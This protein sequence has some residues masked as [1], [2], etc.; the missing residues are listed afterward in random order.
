[1]VWPSAFADTV[2][3]PKTSPAADLTVPLSTTSA[4]RAANADVIAMRTVQPANAHSFLMALLLV[5]ALP[6]L[7]GRRRRNGFDVGDDGVDLARLEM[8]AEPRHAR[9]A[10][11]DH[12]AHHVG[13]AAERL[14]RQGGAI[15]RAAALHARVADAARL[16]D[17]PPAQ[18]LRLIERLLLSQGTVRRGGDSRRCNGKQGEPCT[19]RHE[20]VLPGDSVIFQN[21]TSGAPPWEAR[22]RHARAA[23]RKSLEQIA[24]TGIVAALAGPCHARRREGGGSAFR[25]RRHSAVSELD[26]QPESGAD[27]AGRAQRLATGVAD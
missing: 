5:S 14:L 26:L 8:V 16:H 19:A 9:C 1:M 3:P 15:E 18:G 7:G 13:L 11:G 20:G 23:N 2:T 17:Q 21:L 6:R 27:L 24:L 4:A 25:P 12:L 10:V 22:R